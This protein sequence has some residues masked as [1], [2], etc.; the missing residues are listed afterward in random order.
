MSRCRSYTDPRGAWY[1]GWGG[2][3][4]DEWRAVVVGHPSARDSMKGNLGKGSF[5]GEPERWSFWEIYRMPCKRASFPIGALLG[6]LEVV[7]LPDFWEKRKYIWV[8]FLDLEVI[9]I[10]SLE[11]IKILSLEIIKIF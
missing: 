10:L 7:R 3:L 5:N 8:S 4:I 1:V 6:N 11:V 9:K 2:A